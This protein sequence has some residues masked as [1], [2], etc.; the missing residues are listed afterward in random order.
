M[1]GTPS[2]REVIKGLYDFRNDEGLARSL[3]LLADFISHAGTLGLTAYL[4][5]R[6]RRNCRGLQREAFLR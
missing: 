6:T 5:C 4:G 1:P 3:T 2:H